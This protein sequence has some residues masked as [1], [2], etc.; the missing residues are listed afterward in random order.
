MLKVTTGSQINR[1]NRVNVTLAR[2]PSSTCNCVSRTYG[3]VP[4]LAAGKLFAGGGPLQKRL[5]LVEQKY[6]TYSYIKAWA[7]SGFLATHSCHQFSEFFFFHVSKRNVRILMGQVLIF[8][9]RGGNTSGH[10]Q[11]GMRVAV[12]AKETLYHSGVSRDGK[13]GCSMASLE[14]KVAHQQV[15]Y[16]NSFQNTFDVCVQ[17]CH[18]SPLKH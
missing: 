15:I 18:V 10:T 4:E 3:E 9:S 6:A 14:V 16:S 8:C 12:K 13:Q 5:F 1:R 11:A 2:G 7:E 17:S